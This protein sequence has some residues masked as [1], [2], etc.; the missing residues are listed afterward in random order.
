MIVD[1]LDLIF[2]ATDVI[3]DNTYQEQQMQCNN[4]SDIRE[5]SDYEGFDL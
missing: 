4:Y 2:V 1:I 3:Y 5:D